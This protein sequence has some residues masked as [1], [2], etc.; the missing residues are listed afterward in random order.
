M[1][2]EIPKPAEPQTLKMRVSEFM[3]NQIKNGYKITDKES[4][5]KLKKLAMQELKLSQ[6][7]QAHVNDA[8]RNTMEKMNLKFP[9]SMSAKN[10]SDS[11]KAKLIKT[12]T[13]NPQDAPQP[14]SGQIP[15]NGQVLDPLTQQPQNRVTAEMANSYKHGMKHMF[16]GL[17]RFYAKIGAIEA[18]DVP[19]DDQPMKLADYIKETD[20][21]AED[22]S[23]YCLRNNIRLPKI[24]ELA[25]LVLSTVMV[26]GS[27]LFSMMFSGK[28]KKKLKEGGLGREGDDKIADN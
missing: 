27:P 3:Q 13:L 24:F 17:M 18:E 14:P 25:M 23:D 4:A 7:N 19:H 28:K 15:Q 9:E 26:L 16:G 10:F 21:L 6:G 1:T 12:E 5:I 20:K 2:A 8:L 22:W 11:F